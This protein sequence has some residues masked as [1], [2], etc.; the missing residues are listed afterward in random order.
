V[1][2]FYLAT[3]IVLFGLGVVGLL[4]YSE[5]KRS[6]TQ[7]SGNAISLP[8]AK[9][10]ETTAQLLNRLGL[11]DKGPSLQG[12]PT[13]EKKTHARGLFSRLGRKRKMEEVE[14]MEPPIDPLTTKTNM[15]PPLTGTSSLRTQV[16]ESENIETD[17]IQKEKKWPTHVEATLELSQFKEKYERLEKLLEEKNQALEKSE[18]AFE[19]ELRNRKEFNKVK[20]ILEKELKDTKVKA[21]DLQIELTNAQTETTGFK[22]RVNQLELKV[23]KLEKT[24]TEHE[25]TIQDKDKKIEALNARIKELEASKKTVVS[26]P[27]SQNTVELPPEP[28][29]VSQ[30][31]HVSPTA[32][33]TTPPQSEPTPSQETAS[34]PESVSGQEEISKQPEVTPQENNPE[35]LKNLLK[36][37]EEPSGP[38]EQKEKTPPSTPTSE[39]EGEG[40]E[41]SAQSPQ[42]E[43][44]EELKLPPDIFENKKDEP[45]PTDESS[46]T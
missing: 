43:P 10:E 36:R 20:D 8:P 37:L 38:L 34:P 3:T 5:K 18:K 2:L 35:K 25:H 28:S 45:K 7:A 23:T 32:T 44:P 42:A 4:L 21:R 31:T 13:E 9:K 40:V 16:P 27:T 29:E 17:Y 41:N 1:I 30:P 14:P 22:N 33:E 6:T 12:A 19:T 46:Q 24:I 39:R 15:A 11:A 26:S